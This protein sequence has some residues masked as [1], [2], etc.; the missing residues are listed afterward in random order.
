MKI[1]KTK[2][3]TKKGVVKRNPPRREPKYFCPKCG[4]NEDY[5]VPMKEIDVLVFGDPENTEVNYEC[6]KCGYILDGGDLEEINEWRD[7]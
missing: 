1:S 2:H 5:D 4:E 3:V 6:K 7:D